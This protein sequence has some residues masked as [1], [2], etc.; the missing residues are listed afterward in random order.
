MMGT[1]SRKWLFPY[2][3][4]FLITM[5]SKGVKINLKQKTNSG[6]FCMYMGLNRQQTLQKPEVPV[7]RL[8][9]SCSSPLGW[10]GAG[11]AHREHGL[12]STRETQGRAL[13][14]ALQDHAGSALLP[15][16]IPRAR[17]HRDLLLF[18]QSKCKEGFLLL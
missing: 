2:F 11:G 6:F 7:L 3:F 14:E 8:T 16:G 4:R 12:S 17:A 1:A 18:I 10:P 15:H 5:F 13:D 9:L